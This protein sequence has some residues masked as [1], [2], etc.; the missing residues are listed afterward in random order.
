[1]RLAVGDNVWF[2]RGSEQR[3]TKMR[4]D[5]A[6]TAEDGT[7]VGYLDIGG[8]MKAAEVTLAGEFESHEGQLA[9]PNGVLTL[10][11]GTAWVTRKPGEKPVVT[12]SAEAEGMVGDY[13][14]SLNPSGQIYPS[15]SAEGEASAPPLA[16]NLG[17]APRLEEAYVMALLKGPVVAPTR[18]ESPDLAT[19]LA[20]PTR[21]GGSGGEITGIRLPPFGDALGMQEFSLDVALQGPVRLR[22]GG[23]FRAP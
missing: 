13:L 2:R 8:T 4:I 22:L 19:L 20:D 5:P 14:V 1:V 7:P 12:V 21:A 23:Q 9:F 3:P 11:T 17:S 15:Q 16:L 18:G 10:R 6:R